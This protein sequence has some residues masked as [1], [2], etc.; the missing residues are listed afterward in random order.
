[1][2]IHLFQPSDVR[3]W[4]KPLIRAGGR[5]LPAELVILQLE[6]QPGEAGA[7][8]NAGSKTFGAV[9]LIADPSGKLK[10]RRVRLPNW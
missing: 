10:T 4:G 9:D 1:M 7:W 5:D 8:L 3:W 6:L 2:T